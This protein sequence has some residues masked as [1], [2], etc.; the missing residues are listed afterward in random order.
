MLYLLSPAKSLDY[1]TP[2][3]RAVAKLATDPLFVERSA[4]LI[5]LM[6]RRSAAEVA[7]MMDLSEALATLNVERY[8]T[9]SPQFTPANSKPAALAFDGDVYGGLRAPELSLADL[10]WAQKHVAILSGLHGVLR[11]LDR[12]Q[13]Y[14]LEM[15]TR[16]PNPHG[17]DLY[18][19]WGDSI[20][21]HLNERAAADASP[22]IVN[23]ASTEYFHA[24]DR[25][26]VL[27]PRVIECVFEDWKNGQYKIISF[28][29]KRARG[30]MARHAIKK[31]IA[32]PAG[33]KKFD[34]E[35]YRFEAAV[36]ERDRFVFRRRVD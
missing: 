27:V 3:P 11:P 22:V 6:R 4:E 35:G 25:K 9:W 28:F 33:L 2:T 26:K 7:E 15:G 12:L 19:Y 21:E 8:A 16:L 5:A 20:A 10:R 23:L 18:A 1:A 13:P 14:R 32:T 30:L 17:K 29:A 24:A 36:S 34:A 31:R